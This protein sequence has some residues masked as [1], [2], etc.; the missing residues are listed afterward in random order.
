MRE[1]STPLTIEVPRT[2]NLT[3]DVVR[4]ASEGPDRVAFGIRGDRGWE[5]VTIGRFHEQVRSVVMVAGHSGAR[6]ELDL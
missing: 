4:R 1:Y 5:D 6:L 3:D 2:G